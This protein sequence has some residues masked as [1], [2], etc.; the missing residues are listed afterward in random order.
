MA[1]ALQR[2]LGSAIEFTEPQGGLF[3]WARLTGAG[4][5]IKDANVLA[6][7]AIEKNVAFV[8]GAPFFAKDPDVATLRLSFATAGVEKI[9]EGL[10]R[11]GQALKA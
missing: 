6:Q 2:E 7:R 5:Q 1:V 8:P 11:L 4:G 10:Q 3:F 9:E